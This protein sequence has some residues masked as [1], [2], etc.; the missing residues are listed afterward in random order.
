[1]RVEFLPPYSPDFNPIEPSFS[2]IKSDIRRKGGIMRHVMTNSNDMLEV[3]DLLYG[4]IWSVT[5]DDAKGWF[6]KSGYVL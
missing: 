3:F 1:M 5:A 6:R 2:K 4:S